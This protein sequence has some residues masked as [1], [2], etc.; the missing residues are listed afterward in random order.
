M[1]GLPASG[2]STFSVKFCSKY[3]LSSKKFFDFINFDRTSFIGKSWHTLF[4]KIIFFSPTSRLMR[5]RVSHF[6]N[7]LPKY[8]ENHTLDFFVRKI[9]F[10]KTNYKIADFLKQN[11]IVNEGISQ[12]LVVF[13]VEF[14]LK[15]SDFIEL[16][17]DI[18][19]NLHV[20]RASYNISVAD[21]VKSFTLRNRHTTKIDDLD[22][23]EL[24]FF[25]SSFK[26]YID[27]LNDN[28]EYLKLSRTRTFEDNCNMLIDEV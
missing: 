27:I 11:M 22:G 18:F 17:N 19:E 24:L 16:V 4:Y 5:K 2:K 14:E 6:E 3:K 10:F 20:V 12:L 23:E 1:A 21:C 25:L 7:N 15:E 26:F 9:I 8:N 13:A 28:F